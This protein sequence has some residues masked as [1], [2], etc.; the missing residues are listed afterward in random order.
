MMPTPRV[1]IVE[2]R[3]YQD[4]ADNLAKGAIP[5]LDDAGIAYDRIA[6]PGVFEVPGAIRFALKA[7]ELNANT[8]RY[9]GFMAMGCVIRGETDHYD[10]ICRE[11]SRAIMDLAMTHC[12]AVGFGILTCETLEQARVRAS[13]DDKNKG[14]EVAEACLR[15]MQLKQQFHLAQS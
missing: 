2:A 12:V 13:V 9:S 6:V 3:Y 1:L 15:M 14:A 8:T 5:L 4:I 11:A 7:M 10:H